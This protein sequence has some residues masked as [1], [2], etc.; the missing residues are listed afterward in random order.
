MAV[1]IYLEILFVGPNVMKMSFGKMAGNWER[2]VKQSLESRNE[3]LRF[4]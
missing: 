3:Y 2:I 4:F 1:N